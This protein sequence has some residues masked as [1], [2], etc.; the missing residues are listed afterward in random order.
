MGEIKQNQS[1]RKSY[2]FFLKDRKTCIVQ[3]SKK[4]YLTNPIIIISLLMILFYKIEANN[5]HFPS[6]R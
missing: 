1:Y 6:V 3:I 5:G 2:I 4:Y